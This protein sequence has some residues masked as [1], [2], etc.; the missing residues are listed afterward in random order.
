[1]DTFAWI[2]QPEVGAAGAPW[3]SDNTKIWGRAFPKPR[4][5]AN[6]SKQEKTPLP[7]VETKN[8]VILLDLSEFVLI[9]SYVYNNVVLSGGQFIP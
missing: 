2:F 3:L 4:L 9:N 5:S 8:S 6:F 7:L 1:M